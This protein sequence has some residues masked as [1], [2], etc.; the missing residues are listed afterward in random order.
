M[1]EEGGRKANEQDD[2][3]GKRQNGSGGADLEVVAASLAL[4]L[5]FFESVRGKQRDPAKQEER[6]D[7]GAGAQGVVAG[8]GDAGTLRAGGLGIGHD[9]R[10]AAG[11]TPTVGM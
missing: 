10:E 4:Y 9:G 6:Q 7:A 8:K 1:E 11:F 3:N 2:E 5:S